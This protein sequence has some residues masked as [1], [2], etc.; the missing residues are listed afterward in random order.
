M[1]V[2][3]HSDITTTMRYQHNTHEEVSNKYREY[4]DTPKTND[5]L[6]TKMSNEDII[7]ELD[8]KFIKGDIPVEI[9]RELRSEY[10]KESQLKSDK[11][12]SHTHTEIAYQ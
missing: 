9:Y 12:K 10:K 6:P 1:K 8:S 11:L 3:G 7:R 2:A 5:N 4:L